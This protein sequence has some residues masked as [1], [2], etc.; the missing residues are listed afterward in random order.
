IVFTIT[1][2][3]YSH[4]WV[5]LVILPCFVL[6]FLIIAG[7]VL[8]GDNPTI[9][10]VVNIGLASTVSTA[11]IISTMTLGSFVRNQILIILAAIVT[12]SIRR[13]LMNTIE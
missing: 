3:R 9:E 12:L 10:S 13:S 6:G 2:E 7:L 5:N 8:N 1:L 11:V 4:F